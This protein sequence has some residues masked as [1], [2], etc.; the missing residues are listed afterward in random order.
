MMF[1]LEL[2]GK[3][4]ISPA[5]AKIVPNGALMVLSKAFLLRLI[6][7]RH[8]AAQGIIELACP[9]QTLTDPVEKTGTWDIQPAGQ[10]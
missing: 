5:V 2:L 10:L 6:S 8:P 3:W 4:C 9:H 1:S 7:P